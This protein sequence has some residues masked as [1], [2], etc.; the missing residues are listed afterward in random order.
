MLVLSRR[1]NESIMVGDDVVITVLSINGDRVRIGIEAP[2]SV[3]IY[4]EE[5]FDAIN[6]TKSSETSDGT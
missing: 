3:I 5:V 4:R 2:S 6:R 1:M